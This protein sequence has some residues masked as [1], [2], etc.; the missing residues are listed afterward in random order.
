MEKM[1]IKPGTKLNLAF[2]GQAENDFVMKSTFEKSLNDASFL[3]SIPMKNGK[4]VEMDPFTK[5][6][7]KYDIGGDS[8]LVE[9]YVDDTVKVGIRTF[10]KF[11]RVSGTRVFMERSDVRI[12]AQLEVGMEISWR[13]QEGQI[14]DETVEGLTKDISAGGAA[15]WLNLPLKVGE[16]IE[17]NLPPLG[18]K[19]GISLLAETCWF[20][21]TEK[22]NSYR[23]IGGIRFLFSEKKEKDRVAS[24]V[25]AVEKQAK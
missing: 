19:H 3:I 8:Y 11:R 24:Y 4:H 16:I 20:R 22:G 6:L 21:D 10:W 9:G 12:S 5:L 25:A 17:V 2:E 13:D 1:K 14:H 7:I 18:R 23:H 15:I